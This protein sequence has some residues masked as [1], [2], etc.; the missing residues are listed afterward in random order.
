MTAPDRCVTIGLPVYNGERYLRPAIESILAQSFPHFELVISDNA[1][2]DGTEAICRDDADRDE[3]VR[4]YR[5]T[6]NLGMSRN[7]NLTFERATGR[8]FKWAADDDLLEPQY[9]A[10]CVQVLDRDPGVILCHSQVRIIDAGDRN[11]RSS[12]AKPC[13][14]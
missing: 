12:P 4:Y 1:S 10:R 14:N 7:F 5:N 6:A 2:T 13:E 3:R 11:H 9:L 8:Y